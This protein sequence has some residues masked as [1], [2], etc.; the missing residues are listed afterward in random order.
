MT[1]VKQGV[2]VGAALIALLGSTTTALA[3]DVWFDTAA[4]GNGGW[5]GAHADGGAVTVGDVN[6]GGNAGNSISVG[7]TTYGGVYVR[8]GTATNAADI[9]VSTDG[10]GA[11][12]DASGGWDNPAAID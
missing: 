12:A 7:N 11:I 9:G 3:R 8:G 5:A 2:L 4:A 1:Q 6:S 10:G